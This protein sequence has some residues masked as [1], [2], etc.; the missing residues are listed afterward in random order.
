MFIHQS[1]HCN[2][3]FL[4]LEEKIAYSFFNAS[5]LE[6]ISQK[7]YLLIENLDQLTNLNIGFTFALSLL[8]DIYPS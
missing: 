7:V 8:T 5:S 1:Q 3:L 4:Q 6:M 2:L